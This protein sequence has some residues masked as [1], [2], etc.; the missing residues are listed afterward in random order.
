MA[1]REFTRQVGPH[2]VAIMAEWSDYQE[3]VAQFFRDLGLSAETN[4]TV[5]GVRTSHDVD[6]VVRSKHAGFDVRWLVE[7]KAWKSAI[8][9]EKVLALRTIVEDTGADRGFIMAES[10]YQSG[11]LEAAR[12]ANVLL[13]SLADLNE[14]L[15]YELGMSQLKALFARV[16]SCRERYWEI[17]KEDRIDLGLRPDVGVPGFSSTGVMDAVFHTAQRAMLDGFPISYNR[18]LAAL[19]A[20]SGGGR[21]PIQPGDENVFRTPTELFRVLDA[22]LSEVEQRLDAAEAA[23]KQRTAVRPSDG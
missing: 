22:E 14:T 17:G 16:D 8:P 23:L 3:K 9:K 20:V 4:V 5:Q 13:S 2:R 21:I 6:V 7:C 15:A 19:S 11:A 10:G 18:T 1:V 12:L